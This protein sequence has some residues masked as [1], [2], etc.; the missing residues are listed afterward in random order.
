MSILLKKLPTVNF[1]STTLASHDAR[2]MSTNGRIADEYNRPEHIAICNNRFCRKDIH[3]FK[4]MFVY[5]AA[6]SQG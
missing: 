6:E 2:S 1:V 5:G 3:T 4:M